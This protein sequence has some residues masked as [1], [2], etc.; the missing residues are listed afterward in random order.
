[1][2]LA[3]R[4]QSRHHFH[5]SLF[6]SLYTQNSDPE[7]DEEDS[8]EDPTDYPADRGDNDA[9]DDE[10][11]DDDE[12]D[13]DVEED[14][15]EEEEE[16]H[17]ASADSILPHVHRVT[18]KMSIRAQ[19]P[20]S[21]PSNTEILSPL[22]HIL[23]PPL[24]VSPPLL[25]VSPTYPLGYKA[26]MIRL[27][28]EIP[29]TSY[30]LPSSTPPLRT[31]PLLPIPLPTSSPPLLLP[32][33]VCRACV[34]KV[35]LSPR[36]RL[37]IDLGLRYKVGESSFVPTTR[38]TRGFRADYRFVGTLDDDIRRDPKRYVGYGIIDTWDEMVENMQGT[39]AATDVA[40]LSQ[41]MTGFVMTVRQDTDEIYVRLD[42]AQ[43]ERLLMSGQLNMLRRD[44]RAH[45]RTARLM[46]TKAILSREAWV[47]SMDASDTT[48]SKTHVT[49]LQS[50]QGPT[51]G[52]AQPEI[53]VEAGSHKI[54]PKRTT[55]STPVATT[56]TTTT[57]TDAHLK[58]VIDQGVTNALA[59][60]DADRSRNG[61]DNHDSGTGVRRQAPLTRECTYP[62]FMKC[63]PLYFKGTEGVVELT[64]WFE[65]METV[66]RISNCSMENQIEFSTCTLLGSALTWWNS[67]VKTVGHDVAYAMTWTNLKKKMTDK[68]C[69]RGEVKKLEGEMWNLKVKGTDVDAI[70]FA[71][72][73]MDKKIRTFAEQQSENKRKQDDNQQQQQ[74]KR[75]NTGRAYVAGSGEKKPYGGSKPLCSKCNYH[76]D[77]QCAPKCHK[78]NR[79]GH[80]AR[81]CRSTTNANTA[82][83]QRGTGAGQKPTCYECGAQGHFKRD[84]PKL[85]NKNRGN[86]GRN[87]NAPAKVYAVGRAGTNPDSNIVT[88]LMPIEL[89]SLDV[90]IGM[91][92]LAKYQAVI[93]CAEKIIC[94]PWGNETLIVRG[95]GSDQ[96][97]KTRLNIISCTK[98][99]KYMLKG[100]PIFL[101][102]VT[103]KET[104]EKS[105]NKRLEDVPIVRDFLEVF[106]E[107][108][109]GLPPTR[110]MEFQID[111]IP[112]A[113]LVARAPYRLA[114]SEM[115]ELSDQLQELF[116]KGFIRPNSLPWGAPVLFVKKKDGSFRMCIDYRELNK[117]MVKNRY[118]LP[119]IDDLFD[120][121]QGS[122]V[123]SKIDL[124]SGYRQLRVREEDI[125]KTAFRTR[126][127]HYEF[128]V[129]PFGL[130]NAPAVFIDLMNRV[131]NPYLDKFMI[132]FID[133]ILIYSKNKKEH[134]EHLKAILEL[135][136]KEEFQGI[137]VDPAKIESIKDWASPK[138]PT[139]IHQF[140]GLDGYYRRFIKGFSK[141][142]KSMTKLTQKGVKFDW[143]DK[144]E[145]PFQ[146]I[147]KKLCS[148]PILDLSEGSED[149]IVYCDASIKG[150]GIVL[151]QREKVIAYALRQL[152]IH[153]KNFTTHDLRNLEQ[154]SWNPEKLE[155]RAD[156][157]L[158]LNGRSWLPCYGDLRTVIMHESHKSKYS[159][160]PGS[161]KMYQDMK[162]LYWW[163]NMKADIATYVSK[164]LT[165]AKVKAEH[166]RPSGLLV[167]PEIPQWKWDNITMDF[168][169]KLPKSSQGY[170]TIWVIVDRLTKS[171]IFIPMRETDPMEKLA[172]MYLKEVVTRHGIP[173]SIICDRDPRKSERT[174][175]TLEDMLRACVIDF[176]KGWVNHLPLVEFS[177]NNSY[178]ASIKPTPFEA[179]YGRKC[180]SLIKQRIQAARDQQKS[181]AD[182]K[183]KPM[184]FQVGDRVMLK[185]L[186]WKGLV[187][188][189][190]RG[191]L[192]PRYVGPFKGLEKVGAIAYKL[193]LPQELSKVHNTFHVS[194]L[195]KC[196]V[197]EPLAVPL[198]GLHI[199]D[200][201]HFVEEPVEIMDY[202]VK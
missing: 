22:P 69:P 40:G 39:P 197:D 84:C 123:Y 198:D 56:T 102:H 80:L 37:C 12:D 100:C 24:P 202:E 106:P 13:D 117:L 59:A 46:E 23:S 57:V 163:P 103:T 113:A 118:P 1:M 73:L 93:V 144:Q 3:L 156:G 34:F 148:V 116:D 183:R 127:G 81:D 141:I 87:G 98:T 104:E 60:R 173:V 184:E 169:M 130:T 164:C 105:E 125:P 136:K 187:H 166:Q 172:R 91:D 201:I 71:T 65:R 92:W 68:Y 70:E 124:R 129:M 74:N 177:Y 139:E 167:Q 182:L 82:N 199:D 114:P 29:S 97:N 66:F 128:Q 134:K 200:K 79:V 19:T 189:G 78:C 145:G 146:L 170:D 51:S 188:F 53:P 122:S 75:Q 33:T 119:R 48:R 99:Q 181:Y 112:G 120:Q 16:K 35:T 90:I 61:E 94:I 64:Q 96:G 155:P 54:T 110:H 185:V 67:H 41:R 50:Q 190:K 83:N 194:N 180:H 192:N 115:K 72:E 49:E 85:K 133:D 42:E 168:I 137:H 121:L 95:D 9:D 32:S 31:P 176:G 178:H 108:L 62:D 186:P 152:T 27:R 132:V 18:A 138:T 109:P 143:G 196:Y 131:C 88:D 26:A 77:G 161:D 58:E 4:S 101:A 165:C 14:E 179:L 191:K 76:H 38:P 158:C 150:L 25:P 15:D 28:A 21:H 153:E 157:T 154:K 162:K 44:R 86:Q 55:R 174:I 17:P 2:C 195:K 30:P 43:D 193:E 10:S 160:H 135:L 175:Q 5:Q 52:P 159:I 45:A 63:K 7:E 171:A 36:N 111:L 151:M 140:L 6:L 89:G 8:E 20:I 147:K 107:D 142:A 47:Q 149:F 11:S 126:Y